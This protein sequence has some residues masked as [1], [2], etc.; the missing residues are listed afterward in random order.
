MRKLFCS[1]ICAVFFALP[2]FSQDDTD[3]PIDRLEF[4]VAPYFH[5]ASI[6]GESTVG[7]I[8]P[9]EVDVS[10]GDLIKN[11]QAGFALRA[12][13][14][15]SKWGFMADINY[16]NLGSDIETPVGGILSVSVNQFIF[17]GLL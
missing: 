2:C 15:K 4:T 13:A 3:N 11:L 14:F 5:M 7:I 1:L 6:S 9:Q 17:E 10:F 8:G 12:E 16:V